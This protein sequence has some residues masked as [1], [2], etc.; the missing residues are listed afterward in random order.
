MLVTYKNISM[1]TNRWLLVYSQQLPWGPTT[2][3][4]VHDITNDTFRGLV[5]SNDVGA[6]GLFLPWLPSYKTFALEYEEVW[7]ALYA[8]HQKA[9]HVL[10][11]RQL[12]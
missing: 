3:A 6:L 12:E 10:I 5:E 7:I 11:T 2:V 9:D 4:H 8:D 1:C